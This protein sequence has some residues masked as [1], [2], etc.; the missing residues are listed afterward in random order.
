MKKIITSKLNTE[1]KSKLTTIIDD[2]ECGLNERVL[3]KLLNI[4][5]TDIY[6][7]YIEDDNSIIAFCIYSNIIKNQLLEDLGA[8]CDHYDD[9]V[10]E[11][12]EDIINKMHEDTIYI[13]YIESI[14]KGFNYG[15]NLLNSII[16]LDKDIILYST[17][18]AETF[19]RKQ[20]FDNIFGFEYI[21]YA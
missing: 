19:W 3:D 21:Y 10:Y 2:L 11:Y 13:H 6:I 12:F 18:E 14:H 8:S 20:N 4:T 7:K 1:I 5:N 16:D 9:E 15:N 17:I